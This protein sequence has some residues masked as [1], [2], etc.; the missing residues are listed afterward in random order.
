MFFSSLRNTHVEKRLLGVSS[1][2][3]APWVNI[4]GSCL[5]THQASI[6]W[7]PTDGKTLGRPERARLC[8]GACEVRVAPYVSICVKGV[9]TQSGR[10]TER[11][12]PPK[13]QGWTGSSFLLAPF[14]RMISVL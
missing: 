5:N 9:Q 1:L 6:Q 12:W 7:N 11:L 4:S 13:G 10:D 8:C 3:E 2:S 14:T